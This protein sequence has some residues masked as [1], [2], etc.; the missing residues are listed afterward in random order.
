MANPIFSRSETFNRP[1]KPAGYGYQQQP[2]LNFQPGVNPYAQQQSFGQQPGF[3]PYA[4]QPGYGQQPGYDQPPMGYQPQQQM[5]AT[6]GVMTMDDVLAKTAIS[7]LIVMAV[8]AAVFALVPVELVGLAAIGGGILSFA[9][10]MIVSFRRVLNVGWVAMYAVCEG[11]FVGGLS[12][13][14]EFL[15]PGIVMSAVLATFITAGATLA[16]YKFFNIQ[17]NAK[18]RKMVTIATMAFAGVMLVN[19]V[20]AMLGVNTG[21][22]EIGSGVGLVSIGVSVLAVCLAVFN[23]VM[24]F[25][26]IERGI[27]SQA[28]AT[29]SWRAAFGVT[30]T[31]VWLY[32]EILRILSYFQQD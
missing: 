2:G 31:M 9:A 25:D 19:F 18:F 3:N 23:L 7:L 14:F 30:V 32:I 6:G 22:R 15:F 4:Q 29:E 27:E 1:A 21:L 16:A 10:A 26:Y 11:V 17:V 12:K 24:D 20:L 5:P 13:Y 28:P 8:A